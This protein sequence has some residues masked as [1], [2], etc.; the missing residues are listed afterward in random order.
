MANIRPIVIT[1]RQNKVYLDTGE[2]CCISQ[3]VSLLD[4]TPIYTSYSELSIVLPLLR[5]VERGH[6][7]QV[8]AVVLKEHVKEIG[9][10]D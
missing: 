5:A 9:W 8:E 10:I 1:R 7:V 3:L 4:F 6:Q 2:L